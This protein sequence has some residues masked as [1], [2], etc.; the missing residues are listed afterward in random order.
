MPDFL[1]EWN[2]THDKMKKNTA[3]SASNVLAVMLAMQKRKT[4]MLNYYDA[5][6][7]IGDYAGLFDSNTTYPC[8][9]YFT[10]MSFNQLYKLKNEVYTKCDDENVYVCGAK[11]GDKG[12]V[13]IAN[14]NDKPIEMDFEFIGISVK[15]IEILM[16]ND[17]YHYSPCGKEIENNKLIIDANT[18]VE[19][20][21]N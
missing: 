20:R 16:I 7:G 13:L 12:V 3:F 11:K 9:E 4:A 18:C 2:S 6:I 15:E 5:R 21:I 17:I 10:M 1:D 8:K 19:I 14:I